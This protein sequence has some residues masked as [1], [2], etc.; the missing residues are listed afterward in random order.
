MIF[1]DSYITYCQF[2]QNQ[3]FSIEISF[4]TGVFH[5]SPSRPLRDYIEFCVV[6]QLS[7]ISVLFEKSGS[8]H[9]CYYYL[10][11]LENLVS[12]FHQVRTNLE[13]LVSEI[14]CVWKNMNL[15]GKCSPTDRHTVSTQV[16]IRSPL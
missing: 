7:V 16:P 8:R 3:W 15:G 4:T 10:I 11:K 6:L 12:R 2:Y 9:S 14:P 13:N 1:D 5:K